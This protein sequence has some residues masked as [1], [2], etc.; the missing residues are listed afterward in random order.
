[1]DSVYFVQAKRHWKAL[2]YTV[3]QRLNLLM[4]CMHR[5]AAV[6][7]QIKQALSNHLFLIAAFVTMIAG[8]SCCFSKNH[9]ERIILVPLSLMALQNR[10]IAVRKYLYCFLAY[11]PH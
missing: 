10:R 2:H 7:E 11:Q 5:I 6:A 9:F 8:L 3:E 1:M 4:R